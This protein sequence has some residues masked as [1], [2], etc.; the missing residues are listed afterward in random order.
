MEGKILLHCNG[1][2]DCSVL[3][4]LL[5]EAEWVYDCTNSVTVCGTTQLSEIITS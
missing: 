2:F 1:K 3:G 5:L 4:L